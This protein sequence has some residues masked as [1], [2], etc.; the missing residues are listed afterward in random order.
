ME[1]LESIL[2]QWI[3]SFELPIFES[4]LDLE[5]PHQ[6]FLNIAEEWMV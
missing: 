2:F 6:V 1:L 5:D 4:A 3:V